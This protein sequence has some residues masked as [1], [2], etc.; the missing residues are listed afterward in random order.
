MSDDVLAVSGL[1]VTYQNR[2]VLEVEHLA[3]RSQEILT[4]VGPNGAGKST[5]LRVLALLQAPT[6]GEVTFQGKPVVHHPRHLLPLRRK[7]ATVFQ[8]PLLSDTSVHGNVALGLRFRGVPPREIDRRVRHWLDR[9]GIGHLADRPA[10]TL[11]GGEA[12]RI[13]L[14]RAFVLEPEILFL[15]EPFAALD[16]PT[17]ERLLADLEAVLHESGITAVFVTHELVEALRL[18]RR[19]GVMMEGRILQVGSVDDVFNRPVSEAVASFVGMDTILP[20]RVVAEHGGLAQVELPQG[21]MIEIVCELPPGVHV[22]LCVPPDEVIIASRDMLSQQ[23]SARNQLPGLVAKVTPLGS[24]HRITVDC[25][26]PIIATV[27]RQSALDLKLEPGREVVATFKASSLHV[28]R[29]GD[30]DG[31]D[32]SK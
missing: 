3:V 12:Q 27:T 18:A 24:L 15:D 26:F 29:R 20:G 22:V 23:T 1:I 11:S 6:R 5:L 16:S 31:G 14:A 32:V 21:Q 17:R 8:A 7:M 10:R 4:I 25:G 30:I 28:I 19:V 2:T 9:M 13:S